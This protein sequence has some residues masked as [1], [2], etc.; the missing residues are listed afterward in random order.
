MSTARDHVRR[1]AAARREKGRSGDVVRSGVRTAL[2]AAL[3][4]WP[5]LL[6]AA[7]R[8]A[9]AQQ[10]ASFHISDHTL[11]AGGRP[12]GGVTASSASYRISL[13]SVGDG[14]VRSGLGSA[15]YH[16]DVSFASCYPPPGEV[17]GLKFT[18][19][20]SLAWDPERSVGAYN[21]YRDS[22]TALSG[23]GYGVCF[24]PDLPDPAA[25]D[26]DPVS[27]GSGFFYLVTAENRL[28]E[29][30]TKGADSAGAERG[31]NACP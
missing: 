31:G 28:A 23:G 27:V 13:E 6:G 22:L 11:N 18:D 8:P 19:R 25:T 16:M 15:S 12:E 4:A 14:P 1:S 30:G 3:A 29:E 5:L 7:A 2:V 20:T 21:L 26:T 9:L 24:Q 17:T 10:S